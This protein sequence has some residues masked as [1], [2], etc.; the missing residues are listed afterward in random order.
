M[1]CEEFV[2]Q[3]YL[4]LLQQVELF[5][6]RFI[7]VKGWAVTFSLATLALAFQK[8]AAGLFLVAALSALSFWVLEAEMKQHQMRHYPR[9]RAIE[10]ACFPI[11]GGPAIDWSWE[12]SEKLALG[13]TEAIPA[14]PEPRTGLAGYRTAYFLPHV[15]LP[16]AVT[17]LLGLVFGLMTARRKGL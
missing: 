10:V 2:R 12:Q 3:E 4:A 1:M 16:H 14:Q 8:K 9:M 11:K 7:T 17:V 6:G 13:Q 15:M 5:D